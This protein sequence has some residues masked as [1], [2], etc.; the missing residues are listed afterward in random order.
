M[1][2]DKPTEDAGGW[3]KFLWDSEKKQFLGR[4]G[5]SWFKILL[6]YLIFYGCLAGIFIGTIQVLLL[7]ISDFEPKYQDRVAPPGLSHTPQAVKTEISFSVSNPNSFE[8]YVAGLNK[9]LEMYN[10]TL[11]DGVSPFEECGNAPANYKTRG[12]LDDTQGQK[13]VCKFLRSWL[14][15][16]SG[17]D[18]PTYGYAEGKPCLIAKLNRIVGYYPKPPKNDTNLREAMQANYN[19][20]I[21][22]IFCEAKKDE[23]IHRI[24]N[25]EFF[26]FGGVGGFP[27]QYYPYYGKRLQKSYL[28]PLIGI[29]FTNLTYNMELR[30]ECKVYG[31]N[32][33]YSEKDRS[34]G[35][36]EVKI[37]VKS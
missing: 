8:K 30:I 4:T 13:R 20:Y 11:Q 17:T 16:C 23:D 18:D 21:L 31:E 27:L 3:K 25:V 19:Q 26:G 24:G 22:P 7:T 1:S 6:F 28:Q 2:Q 29:Q 14:K 34:L 37:E 5:S 32:I 10:D 12:A 15:N 35:R 9:L 33:E 36:F